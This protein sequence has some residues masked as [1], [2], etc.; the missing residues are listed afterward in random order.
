MISATLH[1]AV[2]WLAA[3]GITS[4]LG[5]ITDEYLHDRFELRY[6][7]A[8]FYI[9]AITAV[10]Y[11]VTGFIINQV[12]L[13]FLAAALTSGTL[14]GVLSTLIIAVIESRTELNVPA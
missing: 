10:L 14:I 5:R 3:A 13:P 12:T 11:A 4:S 2:F 8:P 1:G 6:L 9:I 7:N